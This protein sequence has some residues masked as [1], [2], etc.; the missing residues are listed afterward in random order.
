MSA[1]GSPVDSAHFRQVLGH[2]ATGVTIVTATDDGEPVGMAAS[3]FTSL[4]L[5]PPLVLFCAGKASST[6]PRIQRTKAFCV[7]IL[8][9]EQ[10]ALSR[11]F[12]GKGDKYTGVGWH[13]G[14]SG[15]PI[16]DG[17]LAWIDCTIESEHDGGDHVVVI[18]RV[19]GLDATALKPLLYYRGGYGGYEA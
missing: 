17:V 4:S 12:A 9:D 11:Q 2:F 7:N 8:S 10:E 16:L 15:S 5:D 19:L 13:A 3:S 1:S 6:W 18:G 14:S